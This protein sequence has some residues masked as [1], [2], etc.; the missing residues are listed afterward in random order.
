MAL[1]LTIAGVVAAHAEVQIQLTAH[2]VQKNDRGIEVLAP[3]EEIKPGQLV[4]YRAVYTNQG[5]KGVEKLLATLP[6]PAGT[7]LVASTA[8]PAGPMASLDGSSYAPMPLR[9]KVRL[10]DGREV[11]RDVPLSEYR[12]LRWSLGTLGPEQEKT[13]KARV[14]V[15]PILS[16]AAAK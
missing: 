8:A 5:A 7:E 12:Y 4:E 13:V 16:A 6:I 3:A 9:R 14:R 10:A 11:T 15:T 2:R 1:L